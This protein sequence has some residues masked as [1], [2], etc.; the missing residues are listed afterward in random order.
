VYGIWQ[1]DRL[2]ILFES[3]IAGYETASSSQAVLPD[4]RIG[5][6]RTSSGVG[7]VQ[8][9]RGVHKRRGTVSGWG[10]VGV[11]DRTEV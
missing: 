3:K 4:S 2:A 5:L 1:V 10:V 6:L 7:G 9:M 11:M 8:Q